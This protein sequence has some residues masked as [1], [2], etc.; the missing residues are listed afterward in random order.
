MA[1]PKF[2]LMISNKDKSERTFPDFKGNEVT[3]KYEPIGACFENDFGGFNVVIDKKVTID[4]A[5]HW[6]SLFDN[7]E[8]PS[9]RGGG[10]RASGGRGRK[11]DD[12]IPF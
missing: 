2:K 9:S 10:Q 5:Q 3:K 8:Q 12:E 1:R 11:N 4:P 6:V 7:S